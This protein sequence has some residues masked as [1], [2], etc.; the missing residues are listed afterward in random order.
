MQLLSILQKW[1][2]FAIHSQEKRFKMIQ[3]DQLHKKHT[4]KK[5]FRIWKIYLALEKR[6][7][8]TLQ[9]AFD[10]WHMGMQVQHFELQVQATADTSLK[11][12]FF[13]LWIEKFNRNEQNRENI[14]R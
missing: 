14:K 1:K 12:F 13:K 9:K 5:H 6:E 11:R 3:A 7:K 10:A 8:Q 2:L 4:L